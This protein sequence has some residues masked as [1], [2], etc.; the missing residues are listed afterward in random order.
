MNLPVKF[1]V[2]ASL[3]TKLTA[4]EIKQLLTAF[5]RCAYGQSLHPAF[6]EPLDWKL[7]AHGH[8]R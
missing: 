4:M 1:S 6:T 3:E 8:L 7:L 5:E 2:R